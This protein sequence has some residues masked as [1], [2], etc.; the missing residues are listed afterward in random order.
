ME[1]IVIKKEVVQSLILEMVPKALREQLDSS[2]NSPIRRA[3]EI[4]IE[5][6]MS[7]V[8]NMI[9]DVIGSS[10]QDPEFKQKL[11][12][13]VVRQLVEKGLNR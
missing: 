12:E 10:L 8:K 9:S 5:N 2:Y 6:N 13:A 1:D 7:S 11:G 4:A 3:I